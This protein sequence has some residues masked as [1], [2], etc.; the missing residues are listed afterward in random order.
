MKH[1]RL[2]KEIRET[3]SLLSCVWTL[4][5]AFMSQAVIENTAIADIYSVLL[6]LVLCM[7]VLGN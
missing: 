1:R 3:C 7:Q 6:L 5:L 2:K 4:G